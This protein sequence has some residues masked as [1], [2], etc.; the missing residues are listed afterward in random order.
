[1]DLN[2]MGRDLRQMTIDLRP[3][4]MSKW[5]WISLKKY[6]VG[7]NPQEQ[8]KIDPRIID[9]SDDDTIRRNWVTLVGV[10]E[11]F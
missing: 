3:I 9:G 5:I 6:H 1:M 7:M 2:P 4:K 11:S 10:R 8:Y